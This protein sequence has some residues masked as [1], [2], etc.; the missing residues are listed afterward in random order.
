M[1]GLDQ[2]VFARAALPLDKYVTLPAS[3]LGSPCQGGTKGRGNPDHSVEVGLRSKL[4]YHQA[5]LA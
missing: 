2:R 4:L 1:D 5:E 3:G